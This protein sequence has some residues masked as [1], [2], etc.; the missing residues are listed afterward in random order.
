M[1]V[2][3]GEPMDADKQYIIT[4]FNTHVKD[5]QICL[6]GQN[7]KHCGKEGHFLEKQMGLKPNSKNKPDMRGYEMK[8]G[9][10]VTT[11]VDK[12][13]NIVFLN[14]EPLP[15]RNSSEKRKFWEKYASEKE[16]DKPTIGGWRIYKFN[17]LGQKLCVDEENNIFVLYD[18]S[19]DKRPNKDSLQLD[20]EPHKIM[21]WNADA[22]KSCIENK[23]NQK[24][25]FK[26]IKHNNAFVK[27]CFGRP[28]T[29]EFWIDQVKEG[30]IYHDG[31][32]KVNGRGRHVFRASN[33]F[34]NDLITEEYS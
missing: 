28:I 24:G 5:R 21:Q 33:K 26:C 9:E 12:A 2:S 25:F 34:W 29:F 18:Y 4:M 15:K 17:C 13:P 6:D 23:F 1:S 30:F 8:T 19:H 32:S 27:I 3:H 7:K 16:S 31:Y 10:K 20:K 11:Y 22:L 14:G